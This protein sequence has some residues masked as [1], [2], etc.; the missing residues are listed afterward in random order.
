MKNGHY[1]S[2]SQG[3]RPAPHIARLAPKWPA[4]GILA[5]LALALAGV[6]LW[7]SPAEA[8]TPTVLVK[9]T[10]QT[11]DGTARD[12]TRNASKRAQ[13][14]TTGAN[15]GGYTLSSLGFDFDNI[16]A[17]TTAG[18]HLTVTLN[19]V[20]SGKPG[21]ALCTLTDPA[22]FS[23][24]GVHTFDAPKRSPC[25][26]LTANTTYFAVIERVI[27]TT[28]NTELKVTTSGS[29]DTGGAMNWSISNG[30]HYF[31][32]TLNAWTSN[33]S[34]AHLIEVKAF[35][36]IIVQEPEP[37][38]R[39][40]GFDLH[41]DNSDP[42][43]MWGNDDTF[44]V[45]ND[46]SPNGAGDKIYAYNRSDGSR[47][48]ANDF[49]TLDGAGNNR[50]YGICS[51]G[52]TMFVGDRTD[53]KLYAYKMSDTTADSTKDIILDSGN[54]DSRGMWCDGTTV[55][56]ANDGATTANKV[57][58]YTI[59]GGAY[60]ST[61]DFEE[62]YLSTNTAAQNASTPRGIWSNGTTMF[63]AD[64]DNDNVFAYKHSDESQDS[65]KN[66]ALSG[67]NDNPRGMWFDGRVLWVV[68]GTDDHLYAY[69]LPAGQ[70]DNTPAAGGPV[71]RSTFTKDVFTADVTAEGV[72]GVVLGMS[73]S[74]A[75]YAVA[76]ASPTTLAVGSISES[77][78]TV[79][80]VTYT[81]R[82]VLDGNDNANS[83]DLILELDKA[84]PRGFTFTADGV[85][86]SSDDATESA[87][88][89][90]RY[91]YQ[92]SASL[93]WVHAES[94]P[95]VL[96]VETPKDGEEVS[97]D[98]SGIT[99]ST[100]GV[101][102]AHYD[103]QWIR[104]DGT[105]ETDIDGETGSTYTPTADDVEKHLKVRVVFDDDAGYKEY[106]IISPRFGPVVD[107]VAPIVNAEEGRPRPPPP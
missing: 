82:A 50:P 6:L 102:N 54:G 92:W 53:D 41:S 3:R 10:D 47:D 95:V 88:G 46:A 30:R 90:G 40:T 65:A 38:S 107:A 34:E 17:I 73:V 5:L 48:S 8:Q 27:V 24:S 9:N 103:Y 14:F 26:T 61:K 4:A 78:F 80:G 93:S 2:D 64:D 23:S 63:V 15:A 76:T 87:P 43:G 57:F 25:P 75:G 99:D 49:D 74:A 81:V 12:L 105:E 60:D 31:Q 11:A 104:V 18:S 36:G 71:V 101:A 86:Y 51:N 83:G 89:T 59:S 69:D 45:V 72:S 55:Y 42:R 62:L 66:L 39:A 1:P 98:A 37:Y 58:A 44:W 67:D 70:P 33:M 21:T 29:E 97:A 68:D 19:E 22:T 20:S 16:E 96:S 79:E 35:V 28:D 106:P 91:K 85:T 100:D 77:E 56:V 7:P 84:L 32:G 94:I 52:T 13:A